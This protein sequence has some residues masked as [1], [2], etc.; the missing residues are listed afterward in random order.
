MCRTHVTM[1]SNFSVGASTYCTN[2]TYDVKM[3]NIDSSN[4]VNISLLTVPVVIRQE[5]LI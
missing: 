1:A 2:N 4:L 5:T 3:G